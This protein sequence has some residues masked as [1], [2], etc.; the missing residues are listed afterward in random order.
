MK[1]VKNIKIL[2]LM[3]LMIIG[4]TPIIVTA[5]GPGLLGGLEGD[6]WTTITNIMDLKVPAPGYVLVGDAVQGGLPLWT[7]LLVF[8][9]IFSVLWLASGQVPLFKAQENKGPRKAFV[10]GLALLVI[11]TTPVIG[12]FLKIVGG[13]TSLTL[14]A[15]IILGGYTLWVILRGGIAANRKTNAE[16]TQT[17]AAAA[18]MTAQAER[19][20]AQTEEYRQK[21]A[22]AA[23]RGL[24]NQVSSIRT[25]RR[26]L[27]RLSGDF[28]DAKRWL[29]G[30]T[31]RIELPRN[32]TSQIDR[33][34]TRI[35]SDAGRIIQFKAENDRFMSA[36]DTNNYAPSATPPIGLTSRT[37]TGQAILDS[38]TQTN[39][40]GHSLSNMAQIIRTQGITSTN[41][42]NIL[43]WC[44]TSINIT[45]RMERDVALEEQSVDKL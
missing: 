40:L 32:R 23:R 37:A 35:V 13:F 44:T 12:M 2:L 22:H 10:I 25:L 5:A 14:L 28:N 29:T 18:E 16:S 8:M 31:G 38:N 17:L 9:I 24:R 36:M 19:K 34:L 20:N 21:T 39:D 4:F 45:N 42:N 6:I 26:D 41:I 11:F 27:T 3:I 33:D 30:G 43:G 7:V 15:L 1:G